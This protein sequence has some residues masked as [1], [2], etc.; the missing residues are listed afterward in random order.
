MISEQFWLDEALL[1]KNC[2]GQAQEERD[3]CRLTE[4]IFG[5]VPFEMVSWIGIPVRSRNSLIG[6]LNAHAAQE[7]FFTPSM[8]ELLQAFANQIAIVFENDR[9]Y[10]KARALAAA[11]ERNRLARELHDSV[12]Q[13]L[14]SVRL[15]AEAV[16]SALTAGKIPAA[17]KNLEQLI[18]IARDGMSDLRLL[19]FE[20]K[21]PVLEE[22][23]LLGAI[24]KRLEMV[25]TRA[26]IQAE[27]N[28]EGE[29]EL[30]QDFEIQIYWAVYEALSN[31]LKHAKAKHVF[32]NFSF[33]GGRST[34][35]IQDDGVGFDLEKFNLSQSSGL[36]N[37]IDRVDGL[38]GSIK[39]DS[40][41]GGGTSIRIVLEDPAHYP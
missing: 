10:K 4:N 38:G 39:I 41:P 12:T 9:L 23:G 1:F 37:I 16:R 33:S 34:V 19:I 24:Q 21:P 27:F 2:R 32:L 40:K 29:P 6:V 15:Y 5:S 8:V 25:E 3:F 35:V 7:D 26:G 11:G 28:V 18:S 13:S 30:S 17:D 20:L 14:Y 31:V 36:K 22:L